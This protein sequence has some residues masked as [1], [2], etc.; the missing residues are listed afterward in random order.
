[1]SAYVTCSKCKA[2]A[3]MAVLEDD[4]TINSLVLD[5]ENAKWEFDNEPTQEQLSCDHS[6]Y[7]IVEIQNY[8]PD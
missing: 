7:Q 6:D 4:Y 5:D 3:H 1:M 2:H 8:E